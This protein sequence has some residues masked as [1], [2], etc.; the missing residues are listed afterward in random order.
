MH[1]KNGSFTVRQTTPAQWHA[2]ATAASIEDTVFDVCQLSCSLNFSLAG[3]RAHAAA[4]SAITY[5]ELGNEM[6]DH[7]RADVMAKYLLR[8]MILL[9]TDP[10]LLEFCTVFE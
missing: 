6:Y 7:G 5:V 8:R 4:G 3:L 2:F 9:T 1:R 10:F